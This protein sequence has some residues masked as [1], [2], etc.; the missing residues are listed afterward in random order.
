MHEVIKLNKTIKMSLIKSICFL[1][2]F[3]ILSG[4]MVAQRPEIK[5]PAGRIAISSDGNLHDSDDWRAT[6]S[7]QKAENKQRAK[8]IKILESL[9]V[10]SVPAD[11]PV[12]FS[13]L[14]SGEWQFI[15]YYN[16]NRSLTLASRKTSDQGWNYGF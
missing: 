2:F 3:Q 6:F 1:L 14:T 13:F 11:F 16:K 5:M 9:E 15:A 7:D 4:E 12:R 8:K 10:D